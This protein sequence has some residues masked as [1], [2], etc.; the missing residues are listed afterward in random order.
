MAIVNGELVV[1]NTR[2][3]AGKQMKSNEI[4]IHKKHPL[5]KK[6]KPG[7]RKKRNEIIKKEVRD[8]KRKKIDKKYKRINK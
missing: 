3:Y 7:Y 2:N 1:T 8:L 5:G 4:A 6:V